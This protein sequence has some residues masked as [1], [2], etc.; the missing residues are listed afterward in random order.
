MNNAEKNTISILYFASLGEQ[1]NCSDEQLALP[2]PELPLSEL[3]VLLASRG[4]AWQRLANDTNL[5]CA[6][7]QTITH[8]NVSLKAGDELAF[9][10]P[11]TGG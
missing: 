4:D 9:L 10:P 7:N 6:I 5:L 11:V 2:K 8:E 1:L 3:K